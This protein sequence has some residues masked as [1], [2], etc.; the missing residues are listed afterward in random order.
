[1]TLTHNSRI[2]TIDQLRGIALL[3]ILLFN[4]QTYSFFALL[5]P[6]Q[7]YQLGIDRPASYA[8]VQ[9]LIHVLVK[10]Q[11]YTIYSFLFGLGFYLMWQKNQSSGLPADRIFKRRLWALLLFGLVHGLVFWFG[12]VLHKYALLGF[13]LLYFNR[14]PLRTSMRWIAG[15]IALMLVI[16]LLKVWFMPVSEKSIAES[17]QQFD[18]IVMRVLAVWKS[19]TFSQV[20]GFQK[21]GFLMVWVQNIS[22][23]LYGIIHFE[24]MFLLGLIAGKAEVY[25]RL[26]ELS[27]KL[28]R[29]AIFLLPVGLI[30]KALSCLDIFGI[31]WLPVNE[32]AWEL[33][34]GNISAGIGTLLLAAAYLI[35]LSLTLSRY[36]S[37]LQDWIGNAG[38]MGLTNYLGQTILCMALF[39]GY[40]LGLSGRLTL[41]QTFVP[42]LIIYV[43][44]II[45]SNLWLSC[46][47]MGPMEQLWRRLT[48]GKFLS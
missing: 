4:I 18:A 15:L 48:Y 44:Q 13:S 1:M 20:M 45:F 42:A 30:I 17:N 11:F 43:L 8:P 19:G 38:K 22:E 46:H 25:R 31:H 10:G 32:P 2:H 33:F 39:Y 9:F 41:L 16:Q 34:I 36:R 7:V 21:L 37:R 5:R 28:R 26:P 29:S 27:G 40:G 14:K 47:A 24:I 23:G 3:G 6:E 35:L 12:D